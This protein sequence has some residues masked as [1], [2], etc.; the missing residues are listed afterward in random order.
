MDPA[1]AKRILFHFRRTAT[2]SGDRVHVLREYTR[3][4]GT[5]VAQ[6]TVVYES[7]K[8]LS[9]ELEELQSGARASAV[10]T[11]NAA[12][13]ARID[14]AFQQGKTRKTGSEAFHK[15][16][17][18]SDMVGPFFLQHWKALTNGQTVRLRLIAPSRAESVGF[19]VARISDSV[20]N[21][22][23]AFRLR[24]EPTSLFV[25]RFVDPLIF[26]IEKESPHRVFKYT[27]RTTPMR[28]RNGKWEDLDALTLFD[29]SSAEQQTP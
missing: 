1:D 18:T 8:L 19:K 13:G 16:T 14:F 2:N 25:A 23:P 10:V 26:T 4:D 6:E 17:L 20:W 11:T 9:F 15:D 24:L 3:P 28:L 12:K 21:G 22:I 29:W 5:L 27:G 7:G